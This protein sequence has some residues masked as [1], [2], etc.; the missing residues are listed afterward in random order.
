MPVSDRQASVAVL[1][2]DRGFDIVV[3][4]TMVDIDWMNRCKILVSILCGLLSENLTDA[5]LYKTK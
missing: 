3:A 5:Y 1:V 4:G 2:V